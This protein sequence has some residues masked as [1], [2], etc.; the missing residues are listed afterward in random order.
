MG[1]ARARA[2]SG[3]SFGALLGPVLGMDP[4]SVPDV[5]DLLWGPMARGATVAVP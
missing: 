1:D 4:M 5:A 2:P 3:C